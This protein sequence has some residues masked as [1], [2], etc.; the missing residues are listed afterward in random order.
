[1]RPLIYWLAICGIA[2][3]AAAVFTVIVKAEQED[4]TPEQLT[5]ATQRSLYAQT[6]VPRCWERQDEPVPVLW[7]VR[8]PGGVIL[9]IHGEIS[10]K[11]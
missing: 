6:D 7:F 8:G 9:V 3:S 10:R 11:C 5:L 4:K 2:L 1:M